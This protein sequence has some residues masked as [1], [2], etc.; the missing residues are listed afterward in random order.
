MINFRPYR[1]HNRALSFESRLWRQ[2]PTPRLQGR[3]H[4][5]AAFFQR[6][7]SVLPPKPHS[8]CE[9]P[10][11]AYQPTSEPAAT[12]VGGSPVVMRPDGVLGRRE[13]TIDYDYPTL[14]S[15]PT[16][17]K[18]KQL[19]LKPS[20]A[21]VYLPTYLT[22]QPGKQTECLVSSSKLTDKHSPPPTL[23]YSRN[24]LLPTHYI[25][26][27][28]QWQELPK[29]S[30]LCSSMRGK[31]PRSFPLLHFPTPLHSF[32]SFTLANKNAMP[33]KNP[34]QQPM[35]SLFFASSFP[36]ILDT[37]E[38]CIELWD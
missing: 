21:D 9:D 28:S 5:A 34:T 37:M 29:T 20:S 16:R 36:Y 19:K 2:R 35:V 3:W 25:H 11:L 7:I 24:T 15:R 30:R 4:A 13:R 26:K 1:R 8:C 38:F 10:Y 22:V 31:N 27:P 33:V 17:E 12:S 18:K 32:F 14:A 6:L 23:N